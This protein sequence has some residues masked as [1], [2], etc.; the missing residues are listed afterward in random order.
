MS[1][2]DA[3]VLRALVFQFFMIVVFISVS[4]IFELTDQNHSCVFTLS[5]YFHF[6]PSDSLCFI[7]VRIN[8]WWKWIVILVLSMAL[9][10]TATL[11]AEFF[12]PWFNNSL[13]DP[14]GP[15]VKTYMAHLI[16]QVYYVN[17][18]LQNAVWT[19]VSLTQVDL[20]LFSM[21]SSN[22]VC[23][24]TTRKYLLQKGDEFDSLI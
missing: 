6:G 5:H 15:P 11:S 14:R 18:Y 10:A 13:A 16:Q 19:F 8:T 23:F 3:S 20:L 2:N 24:Y 7:S 17:H 12:N 9:D 4:V 22:L 1:I 21:L